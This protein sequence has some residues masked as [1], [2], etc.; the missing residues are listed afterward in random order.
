LGDAKPVRELLEQVAVERVAFIGPIGC[1]QMRSGI[2]FWAAY[3]LGQISAFH[4]SFT[5]RAV[6]SLQGAFGAIP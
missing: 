5:E 1:P 3:T 2:R 4:N 6:C